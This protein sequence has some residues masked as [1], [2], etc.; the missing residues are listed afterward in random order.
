MSNQKP[1]DDFVSEWRTEYRC[2]NCH[3]PMSYETRFHSSGRCPMCG[4]KHPSSCTII[5]TYEVPYRLKR[6]APWWKFW[7][8]PI[9]VYSDN[10]NLKN[11][12]V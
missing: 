9:R 4:F 7:I 12:K 6:I 3:K 2:V 11:D 8:K 5:K 10:K 1:L